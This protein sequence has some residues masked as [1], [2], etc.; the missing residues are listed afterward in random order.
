VKLPRILQPLPIPITPFIDIS[1]NFIEGLPKSEGKEVILVV[2]DRFNKYAH[3]MA[4]SHPYSGIPWS[5]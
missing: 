4:L 5:L 1:M 3:L 2:V